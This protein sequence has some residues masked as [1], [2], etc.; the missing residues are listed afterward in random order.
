MKTKEGL[1]SEFHTGTHQSKE[2]NHAYLIGFEFLD[3]MHSKA[4]QRLEP[5]STKEF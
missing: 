4:R 1:D 3:K 5:G 2:L